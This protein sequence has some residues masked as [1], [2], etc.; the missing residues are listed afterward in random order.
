MI[1]TSKE[2]FKFAIYASGYSLAA[3]IHKG[4]GFILFFWLAHTLS[5]GEYAVFG[6]FYALQAGLVAI[7][8][9][10]VVEMVIGHY[11]NHFDEQRRQRLFSIGN[12]MFVWLIF[13]AAVVALCVYVGF[14]VQY[15]AI[16]DIALIF[17]G[18]VL[19]AFFTLQASFVRLS[20]AHGQSLLLIFVPPVVGLIAAYAGF[21][22]WGT[23]PAFF[24]G[25]AAALAVVF[26]IFIRLR[27]IHFGVSLQV[28]E[29]ISIKYEVVPYV[30]IALLVW[31]SGYGS[32]YMVESIFDMA[33]VATF[34]FVYTI[35]SVMH[36]VATSLNQVWSPRFFRLVHEMPIIELERKNT[37]FFAVQGAV[38]GL[39]GAVMLLLFRPGIDVVGGNLIGY[40]DAGQGLAWLFAGYAMAVPWWHAQNYY[41]AHKQGESL[42]R[43]VA[44][45][46]AVGILVWLGL[47]LTWGVHGIYS[48]FFALMLI[49]SVVVSLHARS[50]WRIRFTWEGP[51]VAACLLLAGLLMGQ[52]IWP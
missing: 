4:L 14:L 20:E 40:R 27:L 41:Y 49:R 7:S 33:D 8:T 35:S 17:I 10:G 36:I 39:V 44:I 51:F 34:T 19:L 31:L 24:G 46:S 26:F 2:S 9:A 15:A 37:I 3:V 48:G 16:L 25:M 28:S 30:V 38:L 21:V 1:K 6:L 12:G 11:R 45:S 22:F 50:I 32:T 42:M 23:L 47:M 43:L 52:F 13:L 18:S 5:R 29:M